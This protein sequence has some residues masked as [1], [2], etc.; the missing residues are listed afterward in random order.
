M[1]CMGG[2]CPRHPQGTLQPQAVP[3]AKASWPNTP[4][5]RTGNAMHVLG[6]ATVITAPLGCVAQYSP[7]GPVLAKQ[8]HPCFMLLCASCTCLIMSAPLKSVEWGWELPSFTP[9]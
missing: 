8:Q 5:D 9:A 7:V 4:R 3:D 2:E 6:R 1:P